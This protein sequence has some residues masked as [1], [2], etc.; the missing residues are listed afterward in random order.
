M[1]FLD[2][3]N[4]VQHPLIR[5]V[6]SSIKQNKMT[7]SKLDTREIGRERK[8]SLLLEGINA[9]RRFGCELADGSGVTC[10]GP[11]NGVVQRLAGGF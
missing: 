9:E 6:R 2:S 8:T 4:V 7:Y 5:F 11:D 10:V 1:G 3:V